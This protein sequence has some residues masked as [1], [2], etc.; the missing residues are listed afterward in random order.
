RYAMQVLAKINNIRFEHDL[1]QILLTDSSKLNHTHI[2]VKD[3]WASHPSTPDRVARLQRLAKTAHI[4]NASAWNYFADPEK[5]Q[6]QQTALL[7]SNSSLKDA[8]NLSLQ[9]FKVQYQNQIDHYSFDP[10][11]QDFYDQRNPEPF[12]L[13]QAIDQADGQTA[14]QVTDI[15]NDTTQE[16]SHVQLGL[17]RD[18]LLL[19]HIAGPENT[20]QTFDYKGKK[21]KS[22]E[23]TSLAGVLKHEKKEVDIQIKQVDIAAFQFFYKLAKIQNKENLL[24]DTYIAYF[25]NLEKFKS[26]TLQYTEL[27]QLCG[28]MQYTTTIPEIKSNMARVYTKEA[29]IKERLTQLLENPALEKV[30]DVETKQEVQRYLTKRWEYFGHDTYYE[31]TLH[32]M[33]RSVD[34]FYRLSQEQSFLEKKKLLSL[35]MDL[36]TPN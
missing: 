30:I 21:Y 7:F 24:S 18:I 35:Q 5:V 1:P 13:A 6:R 31:G 36:T 12:D 22:S 14:S 16:L 9:E 10:A 27:L 23:A 34:A 29:I 2:V 28:F 15:F 4:S 26:D 11:Y 33:Y 8:P 32:M 19:E 20:I 25:E 17:E 3:Q